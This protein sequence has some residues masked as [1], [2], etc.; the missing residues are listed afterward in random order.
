MMKSKL[1]T[2]LLLLFV[3][4]VDGLALAEKANSSNGSAAFSPDGIAVTNPQRR[5]KRR[6]RYKAQR[7]VSYPVVTKPFPVETGSNAD[8]MPP[9]PMPAPPPPAPAQEEMPV[10]SAPPPASDPMDAPGRGRP[11]KKAGGPRIKPPTVNIK[12]PTE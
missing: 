12:P 3:L 2:I 9:E 10:M 4:S 8:P 5:R 11:A 6:R 7:P 1:L